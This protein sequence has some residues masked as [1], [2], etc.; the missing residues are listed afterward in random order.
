MHKSFRK[1]TSCLLA[2][3]LMAGTPMS[4]LAQSSPAPAQNDASDDGSQET[5]K[6]ASF[7]DGFMPMTI[8]SE[9]KDDVWGVPL[10][11]KRDQD[12]PHPGELLL[13]GRHH[14]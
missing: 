1:G 6:M 5:T 8:L 3:L 4:I 9:L 2:A 11:G 13:L 10:V 14:P 12:K 7:V